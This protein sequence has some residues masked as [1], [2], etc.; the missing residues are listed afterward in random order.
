[1][2]PG[3]VNAHCHLELSHLKGKIKPG[4]GLSEFIAQVPK[5]RLRFA[6]NQQK[7]MQ[8]SL[9]YMWEHGISGAGDIMNE[10][11]S[12]ALKSA[13]K[14]RT[15]NFVELFG[16]G[17]KTDDEIIT[18]GNEIIK[19]IIDSGLAGGISPHSIYGG[20]QSL[21][22][23]IFQKNK[24]L[25]SVHFLE[26]QSELKFDLE[27]FL[28]SLYELEQILLVHNVY[29]NRSVLETILYKLDGTRIF[30]VLCPN[31]NLYIDN[32]LPDFDLFLQNNLQVCL[33]TDSL[34]SNH[35]LSILEEMKMI[36][37]HAE[38]DFETLLL[39]ATLNGAKALKME[40]HLG[41][42]EIG[43]SPGVA[44][45]PGFDFKNNRILPQTQ[46]ERLV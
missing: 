44:L 41:S 6:D 38:I 35:Q 11:A 33:G 19:A 10:S 9:R 15:H 16:I 36:T 2:V 22:D 8:Q 12:I 14:I 4:V 26:R 5:L 40:E 37:E 18:A 45:L 31:S 43:K 7:A 23:N 27:K 25:V 34:A 24:S 17:K 30:W 46:V 32:K 29:L 20:T 39:W 1:M 42:F 21:H 3:F 28:H 13:S